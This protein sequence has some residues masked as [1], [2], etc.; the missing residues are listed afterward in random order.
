MA[1]PCGGWGYGIVKFLEY[2]GSQTRRKM[3]VCG[4]GEFW[5]EQTKEMYSNSN[6][7]VRKRYKGQK[8]AK[9]VKKTDKKRKRQDKSEE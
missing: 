8:E 4:V 7:G 5:R 6:V 3:T 1:N 2:V 9:T